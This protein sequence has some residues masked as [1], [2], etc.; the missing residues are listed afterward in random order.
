[1]SRYIR[2]RHQ[3]VLPLGKNGRLITG[4]AV[5]RNLS[6][7]IAAEGTVLLK[8]D[9]ILPLS[10]GTKICTFGPGFCDF[11]FGGGGAAWVEA[12]GNI[13]F[14]DALRYAHK[15]NALQVFL[16]LLDHYNAFTKRIDDFS[17]PRNY[18]FSSVISLPELPEALY[19]Q[20]KTFGGVALF[21]ISRFSGENN[22]ADRSGQEGDFQLSKEEAALFE[23]LCCD[24]ERI[25][26]VLNTCGPVSTRQF[27][28]NPKVS[29]ILYPMFSGG[30]AG[31]VLCDLLLGKRY[32]SGHLQDSFADWIED[33]PCTANFSQNDD[34]V[35]YEEDI[36]VGYRYFTTFAP[37][38]A[39]YPFGFGLSYT[40]FLV[41]CQHAALSGNTVKLT[42]SVTN[43]G[44]FPGKEVVQ[45]Y[46]CAPQGKLGKA[47]KVLTAFRKT[48]ELLPGQSCTVVLSFN[49]RDFGSFDDLGKIRKSAFILEKG[50]YTVALGTNVRDC[51]VVL[52]FRLEDDII[53]RQCRSYMAPSKLKK[54]L[55]ADGTY[56]PLPSPHMRPQPAPSYTTKTEPEQ[57]TLDTALA[58]NKV[59]ALLASLSNA[60]LGD[61]LHGHPIPNVSEAGGLGASIAI[62]Q[63]N[64]KIPLVPTADG[65]TGYRAAYGVGVFSTFFPCT[66]VLAQTWAPKL[67]EKM[68]K[69]GA[70]ELKEN[71]AGIWLSPA[72]NIHRSPL[73]SRNFE[74]FSEDPLCSGLF[75]AG[76]VKGV[77]S[78]RIAAT[79]KHFCCNNKETNRKNSD[80]RVSERALR[81]I[82]L[83]GFEIAIQKAAPWAVMTAYNL[84]NGQRSSTN[85]DALQGILRE[86]WKYDGLIMTDWNVYSAIED[87]LLAGSNVKMPFP[88]TESTDMFDFDQAVAA[89]ILTREQL[90][91]HAKIVLEFMD[92]FE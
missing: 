25:I 26:V 21:C 84:V 41:T 34:Y 15:Q 48:K 57:I 11:L 64:S 35:D 56:E 71:N 68:G 8:N 92:H 43:T 90:L 61:L 32:P 29:A 77:Q 10:E 13:S 52:R 27:R 58:E 7:T 67:A 28:N 80:S 54:R 20:A 75:A 17:E 37:E 36:F 76:F 50:E 46:L 33:Y 82:Y 65:N 42:T 60:Q 59:D 31:E 47:A 73:C 85:W 23:R 40:N 2:F 44:N 66:T 22:W 3:P 53:C 88:V 45:V 91:Y 62:R 63:P 6:K 69:A 70:L 74:Y 14:S 72:M 87:E 30:T 55:T 81:E 89:G 39:V 1:M 24:F 38:K 83:R 49:L 12:K 5:H 4:C 51:D 19:D 16:P 79:I 86:E 9:G 18:S 78:Q